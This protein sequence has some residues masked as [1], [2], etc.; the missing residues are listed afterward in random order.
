MG[1]CNVV[2]HK[3]L[4]KN[5]K[6]RVCARCG[7]EQNFVIPP[8]RT[9]EPAIRPAEQPVRTTEPEFE[10]FKGIIP[11]NFLLAEL[12]LSRYEWMLYLILSAITFLEILFVATGL[13]DASVLILTSISLLLLMWGIYIIKHFFFMPR[14]K[15]VIFLDFIGNT[16]FFRV[17]EIPPDHK[18]KIIKD[19][20]VI[21]EQV[22][23]AQELTSG[24]PL[25]ISQAGIAFNFSPAEI[26]RIYHNKK[27][28]QC[29]GNFKDLITDD[30]MNDVCIRQHDTSWHMALS[31]VIPKAFPISGG[32]MIL[33]IGVV[34]IAGIAYFFLTNQT[35]PPETAQAIADTTAT[36]AQVATT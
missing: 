5:E 8:V 3:W 31:T 30:E 21:I 29:G 23:K 19:K 17:G 10:E 36:A 20:Y 22:N 7:A 28:D 6:E 34:V 11:A 33:I 2:G 14:G 16:G 35:P 9:T 26:F 24:R 12:P 13:V 27:C 32:M 15:K 25:V 18:H 1:I 4:Y